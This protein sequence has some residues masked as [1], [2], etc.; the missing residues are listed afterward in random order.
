FI[1]FLNVDMAPRKHA[2]RLPTSPDLFGDDCGTSTSVPTS[3]YAETVPESQPSHP[4][5]RVSRTPPPP[6]APPAPHGPLDHVPTPG[7]HPDLLVP[8]TAPYAAYTVEDLLRPPRRE[9]LPILDPDRPRGT[10]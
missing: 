10:F 5:Q 2:T 4:S 8:P 3:T 7:V 1:F 9:G 6:Y